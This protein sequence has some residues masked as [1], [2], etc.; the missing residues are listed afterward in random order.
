VGACDLLIYEGKKEV[1]DD[2]KSRL[3]LKKNVKT[4]LYI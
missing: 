1:V 4:I 3:S 2:A